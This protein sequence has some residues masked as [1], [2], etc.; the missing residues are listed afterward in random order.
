MPAELECVESQRL[1]HRE[2]R[3]EPVAPIRPGEQEG[4][5]L[6]AAHPLTGAA[7]AVEVEKQHAV[8]GEMAGELPQAERRVRQV[9]QH[10]HAQHHVEAAEIGGAVQQV[11]LTE[12]HVVDTRRARRGARDL[13]RW[14]AHVDGYESCLGKALRRRMHPAVGWLLSEAKCWYEAT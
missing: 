5:N 14:P 4:E 13:E 1:G 10:P 3:A 2:S 11:V 12:L 7:L 6:L 9:V 8:R